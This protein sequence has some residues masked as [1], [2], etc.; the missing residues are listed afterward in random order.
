MIGSTLGRL[1]FA[2]G[3]TMVIRQATSSD[4]QA[5]KPNTRRN[6]RGGGGGGEDSSV[7]T[8]QC[9]A[10]ICMWPWGEGSLCITTGYEVDAHPPSSRRITSSPCKTPHMSAGPT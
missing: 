8:Y 7:S 5:S 1:A 2:T 10:V 9:G 3:R 4:T 6:G